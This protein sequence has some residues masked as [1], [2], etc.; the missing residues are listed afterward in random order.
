M[1]FVSY[2][3]LIEK[4]FSSLDEK[5]KSLLKLYSLVV[6][7][8][9]LFGAFALTILLSQLPTLSAALL[10]SF[11]FLMAGF[12]ATTLLTLRIIIN[13]KPF[14]P[15][16]ADKSCQGQ[17]LTASVK[18]NCQDDLD[19]ITGLHNRKAFQK[20]YEALMQQSQSSGQKIAVLHIGLDRFKRI[21]QTL[22]HAAGDAVLR[23]AADRIKIA[24]T[25]IKEMQASDCAVFY[26][27]GDEF[28]LLLTD[29][30]AQE[31]IDD[32]AQDLLKT[33]YEPFH[34][35]QREIIL[36][37]S[38]GT[39]IYPDDDRDADK[40][41]N[42]SG[43][44]LVAAKYAG[45]NQVAHFT[46]DLR[47]DL[48]YRSSIEQDL[49][50]AID[51]NEF[52][53]YYQP[54]VD[55]KNNKTIGVEALVRWQHPRL[56]LLTPAAFLDVAETSGLIKQI[57]DIVLDHSIRAKKKWQ[58]QNLDFGTL[59]VNISAKQFADEHLFEKIMFSL[60]RYDVAPEDLAIEIMENV[61]LD[62]DHYDIA[63]ILQRFRDK[64]IAVELDD[65]GTGYASLTHLTKLPI[66]R[67]KIDRAFVNGIPNN[68]R[69]CDIVRTI[70]EL[71]RNLNIATI[72]E[73][74]ETDEQIR[75]L[76]DHDCY[77]VQGFRIAKP[78]PEQALCTWFSS[79]K[80]REDGQIDL[81]KSA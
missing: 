30:S 38:I 13:F 67:L 22:G 53:V 41:L 45:R 23:K 54:Q 64:G 34:L 19:K 8:T 72:A 56:G 44:A 65:F 47:R 2:R 11:G 73:G 29:P 71:S 42:N 20:H 70:I 16:E 49:K 43:L 46:K 37:A 63:A 74:V 12:V 76:E 77:H 58:E 81:V 18:S 24:A 27:S 10:T 55:L 17:K 15:F 35:G 32:F 28:L 78:M 25:N 4:L 31:T 50:H 80:N 39:S 48:E 33:L 59:A 1:V 60:E 9:L 52:V 40:I 7:G 5:S 61:L 62:H 36:S 79:Q 14:S 57:G 3:R 68:P 21:N 26:F 66:S 75:F 51:K 69:S 6:F